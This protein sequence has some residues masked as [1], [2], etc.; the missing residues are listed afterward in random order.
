MTERRATSVDYRRMHHDELDLPEWD[1]PRRDGPPSRRLVI[2][3]TPRSGSYLL[4]RQMIN[5][6]LGL[7]TEYFR[8]RTIARLS[9]RWGVNAGDDDGYV[10]ELEARRTTENGVFAAKLQW[11]QLAAHPR[12]RER[13]LAP[14]D[15]LVFLYRRDVAAQAVSWQVSLATGLWSFDATV[16][17]R[18]PDVTLEDAG[19]AIRLANELVRQNRAWEHLVSELGRSA[20]SVPYE[21]FVRD[22]GGLLRRLASGMGVPPGSW[23]PPPAE[24][25]DNRL[26]A[27]VEEARGRLLARVREAVASSTRA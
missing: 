2:C 24:G 5:A 10:R 7:P 4:C 23:T 1:R 11:Q 26:P 8:E 14:A 15:L 18:A 22:Q 20:L 27:A 21:E 16:G 12:L 25:R 9:G 13:L 19:Q 3:S 17:P 6:G